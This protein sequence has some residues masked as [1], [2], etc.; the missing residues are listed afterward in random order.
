VI[1]AVDETMFFVRFRCHKCG[2]DTLDEK[3]TEA[4]VYTTLDVMA[5]D[6]KMNVS[7]DYVENSS[8]HDEGDLFGYAC[9]KCGA[10]P[11]DQPEMTEQ[12]M[13]EFLSENQMLEE[14]VSCKFCKKLVGVRSAHVHQGEYVGDDCCWDE[15]LRSTE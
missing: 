7:A 9:T 3:L 12:E 6:E 2:N 13:F 4:I 8:Y 10:S 14:A 5:I 15:R 1:P 11:N